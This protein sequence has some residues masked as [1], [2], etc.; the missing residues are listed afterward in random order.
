MDSK[1]HRWQRFL[2]LEVMSMRPGTCFVC[3]KQL[4]YRGS[5]SFEPEYRLDISEDI[6]EGLIYY[7]VHKKCWK[8]VLNFISPFNS[9]IKA[10][11]RK[12]KRMIRINSE[13]F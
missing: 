8:N 1:L 5:P 9:N 10:N 3:Q 7:Y 11:N 12:S 6:S 13:Q 2:S 4:Y